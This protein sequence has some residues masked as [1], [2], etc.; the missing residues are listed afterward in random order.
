MSKFLVWDM[1]TGESAVIAAD[2]E[3]MAAQIFQFKH[4]SSADQVG[5]EQ[6]A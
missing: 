3:D 4:S 2:H 5:I 1:V 6:L